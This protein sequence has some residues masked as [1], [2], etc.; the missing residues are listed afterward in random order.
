ML[1]NS[2]K[3]SFAHTK[4]KCIFINSFKQKCFHELWF[5]N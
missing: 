4:T 3:S 5:P 2:F 1:V